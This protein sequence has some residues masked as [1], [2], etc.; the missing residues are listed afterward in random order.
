MSHSQFKISCFP[1]CIHKTSYLKYLLNH[2]LWHLICRLWK[3]VCFCFVCFLKSKAKNLGSNLFISASQH[4]IEVLC[5]IDMSWGWEFLFHVESHCHI[6]QQ[7]PIIQGV[8]QE[9]EKHLLWDQKGSVTIKFVSSSKLQ[10][11]GNS[12]EMRLNVIY[13]IKNI[14][15]PYYL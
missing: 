1:F 15:S 9:N 2:I 3:P 8:L 14:R 5:H 10:W 6:F 7:Q 13:S 12:L 11:K 4:S